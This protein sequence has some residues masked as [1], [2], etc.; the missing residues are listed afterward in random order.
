MASWLFLHPV[1]LPPFSKAFDYST[2][3]ERLCACYNSDIAVELT[4][5]DIARLVK[6]Y[7]LWERYPSP[8]RPS[9]SL[10]KYR[11]SNWSIDYDQVLD[12]LL[13]NWRESYNCLRTIAGI[14]CAGVCYGG[15]HLTA[16]TSVFQSPAALIL[17]RAASV[18]I[19]VT[20][21]FVVAVSACYFGLEWLNR[22]RGDRLGI[23]GV[24]L[25][26]MMVCLS[27]LS[28]IWYTLCRT[29]IVVECFILLAHIPESALRVPT[30]AAYIPSFS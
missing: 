26:G 19:L 28:L 27:G 8:L 25:F 6:T 5:R 12:I 13:G 10:P 14:T 21:P 29:F 9:V 11:T 17:W 3:N 30:W 2:R 1:H 22:R 24:V 16:W 4:S 7:R 18:T 23:S 15:M 20:G